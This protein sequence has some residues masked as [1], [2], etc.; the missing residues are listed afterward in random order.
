MYHTDFFF[1]Q[2]K[3]EVI[4]CI[5]VLISRR[6]SGAVSVTDEATPHSGSSL[7]HEMQKHPAAHS[8]LVPVVL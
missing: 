3:A 8:D 4:Q 6:T 2:M 7:V 5:Q 1:I